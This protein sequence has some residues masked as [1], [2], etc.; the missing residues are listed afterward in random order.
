M[1]FFITNREI[2]DE[3]T[4]KERIREDGKETS[5]DNLRYGEYSLT[6]NKFSLYAEPKKKSEV[7]YDEM[8]DANLSKLK[9]S[10]RFFTTLYRK[11]KNGG[12]NDSVLFFV[13]GFNTDLDTVRA[14]LEDL[15]KR[16]VSNN[17]CHVKHIVVFTWPGKSPKIPLHYRNDARDAE[18]SGQALARAM[19]SLR[20]FFQYYLGKAENAPCGKKIHLM[21][22]SMGHR[23]FRSALKSNMQ[24]QMSGLMPFEEI[25]CMAGDVPYNIFEQPYEYHSLLDYGERVHIYF[26]KNDKILDI[27]K[28]TKNFSNMLGRFGRKHK[29]IDQPFIIDVNVSDTKDDKSYNLKYKLGNHWYYYSSTEVV[30]DV[31]QVLNGGKSLY[32]EYP[33]DTIQ[34]F[35]E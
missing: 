7:L 4:G 26:H 18:R 21:L 19:N 14:N 28:F 22:H 11:L 32:A 12:K 13:H 2:I 30:N 23:V 15:H 29:P 27:S 1:L 35:H 16:Y 33:L 25:L 24:G 8:D 31:I 5:Q 20:G 10:S 17:A 34:K 6:S 9:G 3:G